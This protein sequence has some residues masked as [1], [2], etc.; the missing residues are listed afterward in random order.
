MH[1]ALARSAPAPGQAKLGPVKEER[2]DAVQGCYNQPHVARPPRLEEKRYG[3]CGLEHRILGI[4]P[5]KG[6]NFSK[7]DKPNDFA[8]V[9]RGRWPRSVTM[10][11]RKAAIKQVTPDDGTGMVAVDAYPGNKPYEDDE[12]KEIFVVSFADRLD[13]RWRPPPMCTITVNGTTVLIDTGASVN[14]MDVE[15]YSKISPPPELTPC[16]TK[17]YAHRGVDPLPRRGAIEVTVGSER[18]WTHAKC[19]VLEGKKVTLL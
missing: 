10:L 3:S 8:K 11:A 12:D 17:I 5:A 1:A 4:C 2:V 6:K 19:H 13:Q 7:C 14:V 15:Q 18:R 9:F 16:W